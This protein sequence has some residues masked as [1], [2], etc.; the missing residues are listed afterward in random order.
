MRRFTFIRGFRC[1]RPSLTTLEF[2]HVPKGRTQ[3]REGELILNEPGQLRKI[4]QKTRW[5][6]SSKTPKAPD[7]PFPRNAKRLWV[8]MYFASFCFYVRVFLL[9]LQRFP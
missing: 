9:S 7:I 5:N 3:W 6:L 8:K 1:T 4:R 2:L